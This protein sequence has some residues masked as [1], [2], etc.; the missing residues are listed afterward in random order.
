MEPFFYNL[1]SK[2]VQPPPLIQSIPFCFKMEV[3]CALRIPERQHAIT[4]LFH[5]L[6]VSILP[7]KTCKAIFLEPFICPSLNS[8]GV[9]T[10][11]IMAP[12]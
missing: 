4:G 2:L 9:L 1:F 6:I 10:S 12:F 7:F 5:F 3:A 8:S 11:K